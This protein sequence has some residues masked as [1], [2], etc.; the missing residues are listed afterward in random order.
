[1]S[2]F[3]HHSRLPGCTL[4]PRS[5]ADTELRLHSPDSALAGIAQYLAEWR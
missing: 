2:V 3:Y 4:S 1:M 5:L